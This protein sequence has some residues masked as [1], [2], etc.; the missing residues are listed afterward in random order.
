MGLDAVEILMGWEQAFD[1][2]IT[3]REAEKITTPRMAIHLITSKLEVKENILRGD[4]RPKLILYN[5]LSIQSSFKILLLVW[6]KI[7]KLDY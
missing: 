2:K 3:D 6:L 4:K 7:S 1:V 5:R